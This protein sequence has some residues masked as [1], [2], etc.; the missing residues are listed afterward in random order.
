MSL[1][2]H[3]GLE[4]ALLVKLQD[5]AE[6]ESY[7]DFEVRDM[8]LTAFQSLVRAQSGKKLTVKESEILD[9]SVDVRKGSY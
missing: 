3:A 1:K 2:T 7:G 5:A 9:I 8:F 4:N 6:A